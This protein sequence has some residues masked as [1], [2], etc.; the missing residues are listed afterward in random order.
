[1]S[2]NHEGRYEQKLATLLESP[3]LKMTI[4]IR[5]GSIDKYLITVF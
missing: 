4:A 2:G 1:M 5:V 3:G